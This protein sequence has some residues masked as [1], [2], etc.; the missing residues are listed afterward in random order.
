[1]KLKSPLMAGIITFLLTCI[2][3]LGIFTIHFYNLYRLE[4]SDRQIA[5]WDILKFLGFTIVIFSPLTIPI[6]IMAMA[7]VYHHKIFKLN[8]KNINITNKSSLLPLI[9]FC[10]LCFLW[11]SFI[12]PNASLHQYGFLYDM[13]S[14]VPE[15]PLQHTDLNRFKGDRITS[16]LLE[17]YKIT[18]EPVETHSIFETK[19]MT[20]IYNR[21]EIS[22]MLGFPFLIFI[23][24]HIG[25]FI[26]ILT[27]RKKHLILP[28]IGIYIIV[29]PLMYYLFLWAER[30]AFKQ[31][32]T[33]LEGQVYCL[34]LLSIIIFILFKYTKHRFQAR[35]STN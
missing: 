19:E 1:M 12:V 35:I 8:K 32:I 4:I 9:F 14:K 23:S 20:D 5:Y 31:I 6:S 13:R 28:L 11:V 27:H 24:Y 18:I 16:N 34:L 26:G 10:L 17:L 15:E 21:I 2:I 29:L 33:P 3:L 25:K 7:L 30:L 22:K